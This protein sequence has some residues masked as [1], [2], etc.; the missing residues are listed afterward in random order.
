MSENI[1]VAQSS[2]RIPLKLTLKWSHPFIT[3][4][5]QHC[6]RYWEAVIFVY[7]PLCVAETFKKLQK[8]FFFFLQEIVRPMHFL[9]KHSF[10][11]STLFKFIL[12]PPYLED[13]NLFI[14][15][16]FFFKK[17]SYTLQIFMAFITSYR[18]HL[19]CMLLLDNGQKQIKHD[20]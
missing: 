18:E 11:N 20:A 2:Y 12:L 15:G 9:R 17:K 14:W 4:I 7:A 6:W 3:P 5:K 19:T 13:E 8:L 16:F 10:Y 1:Q